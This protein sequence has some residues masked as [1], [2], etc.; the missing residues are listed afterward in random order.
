MIYCKDCPHFKSD[1]EGNYCDLAGLDISL[2]LS[3]G[4]GFHF[5]CPLPE[6]IKQKDLNHAGN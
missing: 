6:N 5:N 3:E 4:E 2:K 1:S